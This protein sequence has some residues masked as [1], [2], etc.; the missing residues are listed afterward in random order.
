ML[1]KLFFTSTIW[2]RVHRSK[3]VDH[4]LGI[5]E[6]TDSKLTLLLYQKDH[7]VRL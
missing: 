5:Y 2:T 7:T 4:I 6:P 3:A 1:M